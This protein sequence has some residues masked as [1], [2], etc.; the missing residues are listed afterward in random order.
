MLVK[1]KFSFSQLTVLVSRAIFSLSVSPF[2]TN[3]SSAW[4]AEVVSL[5]GPACVEV[6]LTVL[7]GY[8]TLCLLS[9]A[10]IC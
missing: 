8:P 6:T 4:Q 9:G 5:N 7:M 10:N 3:M 1:K 2:D